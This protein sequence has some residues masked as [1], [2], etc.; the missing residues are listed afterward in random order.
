MRFVRLRKHRADQRIRN[1][2]SETRIS[3][4]DL[5]MPYFVVEG[6]N[7]KEPIGSMPGIYRLSVDNLVKDIKE[8]RNL[9]IK[10]VLVFGIPA[11]KDNQAREAYKKNGIVQK[12]VKAIKKDIKD[13]IVITDVCLCGYTLHGHC[14]IVKARGH[15][16]DNDA[17]LKILA[18]I[19]LSHADS[20]AD[21]VAPS[22]MMD[23]QVRA[24]R[25]EL[26][27]NDFR[28]AGILAY[29]AKYASGFYGPFREAMDSAPEFGDRKTYQMDYRNSDEALKEIEEDINEGADIVM[30]KPAMSYLDIVYRAKEK[31]NTPLAAYNVS[32]EYSA[33]K[34]LSE[35][36]T[37]K[38]RDLAL[39]IL[40][41]IKRA[42]ADIIITYYAKKAAGWLK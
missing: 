6:R 28:D 29:S 15:T 33:V 41:S 38:E 4:D 24:I 7:K 3:A 14:G 40:T 1:L 11:K 19:A 31:F 21:F 17:T 13:I 18:R 20:G 32:G 42:G 37:A 39:E 16:V 35:G 25:E 12:A 36:N 10:A 8:A 34:K 26:D 5:V 2:F 27:K 9:G 22:A 30:V 23:G